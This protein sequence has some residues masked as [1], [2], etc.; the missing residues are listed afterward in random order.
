MAWEARGIAYFLMNRFENAA[1]DLLAALEN[2]PRAET[3]L[4]LV[5]KLLAL[6]SSTAASELDRAQRDGAPLDDVAYYRSRVAAA[7][8]R[9]DAAVSHARE[10][11]ERAGPRCARALVVLGDAAEHRGDRVCARLYREAF[12]GCEYPPRDRYGR[13]LEGKV[14]RSLAASP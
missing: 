1:I 4:W 11:I 14:Q 13:W 10:C 8:G 2:D 12:L 9:W 5:E 3:R 7:E 6:H